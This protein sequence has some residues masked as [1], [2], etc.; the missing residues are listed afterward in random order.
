M[1]SLALAVGTRDLLYLSVSSSWVSLVG[2]GYLAVGF[3]PWAPGFL[4]LDPW[5]PGSVARQVLSFV[6]GTGAATYLH[7]CGALVK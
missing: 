6:V 4:G 7:A 2:V 5:A 3:D 1:L